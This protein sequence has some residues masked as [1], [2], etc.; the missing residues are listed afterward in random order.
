MTTLALNR[1]A[2]WVRTMAVAGPGVVVMLAD[3]DAG[4][5]ITAAQSGAQW[6]YG[7]LLLQALLVPVLFVVQEL[8]LRLGIV[9]GK[10]YGDLIRQH[11]GAHW[12]RIASLA[13]IVAC[14]GALI[15][16]LSGLASVGAMYGIPAGPMLGL[17]IAGLCLMVLTGSYRSVERIALAL[18]AFELVFVLVALKARPEASVIAQGALAMPFGNAAYLMLISANIGA[19]IMPWMVSFHHSSVVEKG[20]GPAD[21]RVARWD[22]AIGAVVTQ[23][24]MAA[25]LVLAAVSVH[26]RG[27]TFNGFAD[28]ANALTPYFGA[29]EGRLLFAMGLSGAALVATIVVTLTAARAAGDLLGFCGLALEKTPREA[30]A[31][32]LAYVAVLVGSALL[33]AS[34]INQVWLGI[35]V[36]T[37]NTLLLPLVLGFLYLLAV[38]L[39]G[40]HRLRGTYAAVCA[41]TLTA[42][43]GLGVFSAIAGTVAGI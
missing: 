8:A 17:V 21:L 39:P 22:T 2:R 33:V 10:S 36:E 19:V 40:E 16:E 20:L 35:V 14:V 13:M 18:G 23:V 3:T 31:F 11:F 9:T 38:R 41:V 1:S 24:V 25:V 7:L 6:G 34:G 30:P 4:S 37:M 12:T 32:Y 27:G 28:L 26:E 42:T 5:V 15:T 43:V 29:R